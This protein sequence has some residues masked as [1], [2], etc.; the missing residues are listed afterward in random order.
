M[1]VRNRDAGRIGS[2]VLK[3]DRMNGRYYD[4]DTQ[5]GTDINP[6]RPLWPTSPKPQPQP[7]PPKLDEEPVAHMGSDIALL[8]PM[9]PQIGGEELREYN[10]QGGMV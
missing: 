4:V 2:V 8:D 5:P 6:I 3:Y 10:D 9:S 1:Q 7:T